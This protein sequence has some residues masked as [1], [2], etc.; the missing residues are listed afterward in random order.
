MLRN[1]FKIAWRNILGNPLFSAINIIGLSIGLAC[2]IIITLFVRYELSY[3]QNWVDADRTYR[4][5]RDFFGNNLE[6][7]AV[8]PP[9]APLMK[10]DFPE[11]EDITRILDAGGVTMSRGEIRMREGSLVIADPNVFEFFNLEFVSGDAESALAGPTN[12]VMTERA[13]ERYFGDEEPIGQVL[14]LM[15]QADVTVTG[16]IKD[17]P[18]NTHMAFE[19]IGSIDAIPMIMGPGEMESWGSNNYYTYLRLPEG[20]D[21]ANLEA[22]FNDFLVR[23][24]NEDAESSSALG[25]QLLTDI[26][27]TSDRDGEWQTNGSIATVYTFSAVALFVL[28]IACINF[29]NLT[30]ARSTQRA[31][32]VGVRKVVG[33]KRSQLIAQFMGESIMLTA[34]AMLLAVAI[35]ELALPSFAAYLEKPLNFSLTDPG[36]LLLLVAS[37]AVVGTF[38]GSYPAFFLS[39]F[40]PVEVL[41]GPASGSGSVLLRK[42]L[43]VTQFATSIA[44]LIA[45]GVVMAQMNYARDIDMG[46]DRSRNLISTLP[47][48]SDFWET[49]EPMKAELESHPDISSV[50][51]SSRL[52]SM[53]NNDGSGYIAEGEQEVMENF[54]AI[55]N[56]KVDHQWFDHYDIEFLAGRSFL[57]SEIRIDEVSEEN[58]VVQAAAILNE[59]AARRF[60]WSPEEAIGKVVRAPQNRERDQFIDRTVVGV[61]PDI[62]F[63]SLHN[64][65]KAT[66]YEEP[67]ANYQRRISVKLSAGDHG[68]AIAHFEATWKKLVPG[69]P[70]FWEFLDDRFDALYRSEARQAQMFAVFSAFAIFVAILG[71]FGLASFTTERRTKEIGIR[72]VMGASVRDIVMLLTTDFTKL[73][74]IANIIAWPVA[75]YFMNNWLSRFAYKAPFSEWAWLFVASALAALAAAWLTIALQAGRAA[76]ARPVLALRYE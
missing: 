49:F 10:Q 4:V 15:D 34:F 28:L 19:I 47:Y 14:N 67:N 44:L 35:V 30:T 69:D 60:G 45:T 46:F 48:F 72:K 55:A 56:I 17:L 6:L 54:L 13:A 61:V 11:V 52:P 31:R 64:E 43:V 22:Q 36:S 38:A 2:C 40:R 41:K 16:I 33:A 63:S 70:V 8:A 58:P 59:S 68:D 65:M 32:E 39:N 73:V 27:L 57:E 7:A 76:T 74:L 26:H 24:W 25:L 20:Y 37:I 21:P 53:Q 29:M 71:L 75:Y 5:T 66:I 62:H 42:V 9:I 50:V 1:Y 51:L 12:I 23:H 3:D 18:D